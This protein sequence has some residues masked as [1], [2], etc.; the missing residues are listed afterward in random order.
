MSSS[1]KPPSKPPPGKGKPFLPDDDLLS[2]LDAWDATFDALHGAPEASES[3]PAVA[4]APMEWPTPDPAIGDNTALTS[5]EEDRIEVDLEDQLTL[6][7]AIEAETIDREYAARTSQTLPDTLDASE[8]D[9]SDIGAE[10][11]PAALGE[12]LGR[13]STAPPIPDEEP[14]R[15]AMHATRRSRRASDPPRVRRDVTYGIVADCV[16]P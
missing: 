11:E 1:S 10:E 9:F 12:L 13:S 7:G 4:Q 14:D 5:V 3:S 16:F 8:T 6:D 15:C 2:E